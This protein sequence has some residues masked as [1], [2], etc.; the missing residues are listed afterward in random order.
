M[1]ACCLQR[2]DWDIVEVCGVFE[3]DHQKLQK[4]LADAN[5]PEVSDFLYL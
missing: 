4:L 5:I 2:L 1:S 3:E